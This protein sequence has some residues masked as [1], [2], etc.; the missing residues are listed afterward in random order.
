MRVPPVANGDACLT[1]SVSIETVHLEGC[2]MPPEAQQ[3]APSE[4][5][6][7]PPYGIGSY[8]ALPLVNAGLGDTLVLDP[9]LIA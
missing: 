1:V 3:M 5:W 8:T 9:L 2:V 7:L 6:H 4:G